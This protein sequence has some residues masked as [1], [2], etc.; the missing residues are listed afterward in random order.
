MIVIH[1]HI[2]DR[3]VEKAHIWINDLAS[4]DAR[5]RAR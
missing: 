2:V 4:G 5:R 3:T 1:V